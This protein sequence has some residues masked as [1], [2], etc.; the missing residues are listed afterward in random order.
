[1]VVSLL[2]PITMITHKLHLVVNCF[3]FFSFL[4]LGG[5]GEGRAVLHPYSLIIRVYDNDQIADWTESW[6]D[7]LHSPIC[8][9]MSESFKFV[10]KGIPLFPNLIRTTTIEV[11][12]FSINYSVN[13]CHFWKR[14]LINRFSKTIHFYERWYTKLIYQGSIPPS[15][16]S[17]DISGYFITDTGSS[18]ESTNALTGCPLTLQSI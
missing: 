8:Y 15:Y 18:P 11:F 10:E 13:F 14:I 1:M 7:F 16:E 2:S 4:F 17:L 9:F 3:D 5:E 12:S 6:H